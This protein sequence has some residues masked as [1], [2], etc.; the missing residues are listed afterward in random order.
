MQLPFNDLRWIDLP[1]AERDRIVLNQAIAEALFAKEQVDFYRAH[2][3][4]LSTNNIIDIT[5]LEEFAVLLPEVNRQHLTKNPFQAFLPHV[6]REKDPNKGSLRNKGTGGTTSRPVNIFYAPEDWRA[7]ANLIAREIQYDFKNKPQEL[8]NLLVYG[9]YHG[10]HITN[11]LYQA[12]FTKLNIDFINRASTRYQDILSNFYFFQETRPTALLGP[13]AD[14]TKKITKGIT[15]ASFLHK[16]ARYL[17]RDAYNLHKDS[18][19]GFYAIFWSSTPMPIDLQYYI[20][21]YLQVPYQQSCYGFTEVGILGVTCEVYPR[22]FHLL[23]GPNVLL[24]KSH[25]GKRLIN[26]GE[27]GYVVASRIGAMSV[28]NKIIPSTSTT[29][30]NYRSGDHATLKIEKEA[31]QCGRNTPV[32]MGVHR[33]EDIAAKLKFG[34]Q[35]D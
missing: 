30:I 31:C 6:T 19:S 18:N 15:L 3:R 13:P 22:N 8:A 7:Q 34:C 21:E 26:A 14:P 1:T 27:F 5:S 29:L 25:D 35:A 16:D 32:L 20:M 28:D 9:L 12:A 33:R 2:Y 4:H 23:Y 17:K 10:D 24:I 11:E